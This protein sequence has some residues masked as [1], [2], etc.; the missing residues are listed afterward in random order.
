M[1]QRQITSHE[2]GRH[3]HSGNKSCTS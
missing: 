3:R 1:A 2:P